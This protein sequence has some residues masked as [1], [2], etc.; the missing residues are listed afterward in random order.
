MANPNKSAARL[1]K[2][3]TVVEEKN[4]GSD[5]AG[6]QAFVDACKGEGKHARLL[7][8][9]LGPKKAPLRQHYVRVY[10]RP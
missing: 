5:K 8:Y 7:S 1:R 4:F 9:T 2:V 10:E 3:L 6:A